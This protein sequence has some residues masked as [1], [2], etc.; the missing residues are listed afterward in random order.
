[1]K[2]LMERLT[3]RGLYPLAIALCSF[4]KYSSDEGEIPVLMHWARKQVRT[5]PLLLLVYYTISCWCCVMLCS[6]DCS[7]IEWCVLCQ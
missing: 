6:E 3:N 1:M 7:H 4:L 2:V 5:C